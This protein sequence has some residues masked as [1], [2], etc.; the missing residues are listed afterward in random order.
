MRIFFDVDLTIIGQDGSLRPGTRQLF[1]RLVDEGHEV[2]VWSGFGE[3]WDD[4]RRHDLH[5]I[6]HGVY[7]KPLTRMYASHE[8]WGL[9]FRP[10]FVVDD[11]PGPAVYM[12]GINVEPYIDRHAAATDK[13]MDRVYE[14]IVVALERR[15]CD[16]GQPG[17]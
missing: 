4:L 16:E 12:G 9:P 11:H 2:Y 1:L 5:E 7:R 3:R 15:A 14:A 8:E 10:D 17:T 13:E 6:V